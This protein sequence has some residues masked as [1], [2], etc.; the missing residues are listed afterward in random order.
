MPANRIRELR[1]E[2]GLTLDQLAALLD[3]PSSG[4]PINSS[5]LSKLEI[6]QRVVTPE[7]AA[8]I[9]KALGVTPEDLF[10]AA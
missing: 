6:G 5:T 3:P 8:L 2:R 7:R 9:A 10:P 4:A 1:K